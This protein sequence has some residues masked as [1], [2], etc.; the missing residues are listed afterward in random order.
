MGLMCALGLATCVTINGTSYSESAF[1]EIRYE[2]LMAAS[3]RYYHEV[4]YILV[5]GQYRVGLQ[6]GYRTLD[7]LEDLGVSVRW[8]PDSSRTPQAQLARFRKAEL[9]RLC[10]SFIN[11]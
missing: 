5:D 10:R 4:T 9:M 11:Y 6:D 7:R 3:A 8:R 2:C 1:V